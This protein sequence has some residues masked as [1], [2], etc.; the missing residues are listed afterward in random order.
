L[1]TTATPADELGEVCPDAIAVEIIIAKKTIRKQAITTF[2]TFLIIFRPE[3]LMALCRDDISAVKSMIIG[4]IAGGT[5]VAIYFPL[6]IGIGLEIFL[7][8]RYQPLNIRGWG[9]GIIP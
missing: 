8:F 7:I 5:G 1:K 2:P 4:L 3:I 6:A 9:I